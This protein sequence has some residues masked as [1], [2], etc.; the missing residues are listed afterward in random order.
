VAVSEVKQP[1]RNRFKPFQKR[2]GYN[3]IAVICNGHPPTETS[4][5]SGVVVM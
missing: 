1:L 2:N 4:V 5:R 3:F